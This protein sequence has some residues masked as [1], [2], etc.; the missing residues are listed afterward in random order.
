MNVFTNDTIVDEIVKHTNVEYDG[1][2][3]YFN[4]KINNFMHTCTYYID[5][6]KI[7]AVGS[8]GKI[9]LNNLSIDIIKLLF[10]ECI[11][12]KLEYDMYGTAKHN[13]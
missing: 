1:H 3:M 13:F 10:S 12:L 7:M 2:K 6:Y 9:I 5:K 8:S 4:M 11:E